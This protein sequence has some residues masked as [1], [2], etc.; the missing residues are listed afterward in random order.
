MDSQICT[1]FCGKVGHEPK[2]R[3]PV[4]VWVCAWMHAHIDVC[5]CAVAAIGDSHFLT[6]SVQF[7]EKVFAP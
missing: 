4:Y 7:C 2:K 1:R 6:R 5:A 3:S